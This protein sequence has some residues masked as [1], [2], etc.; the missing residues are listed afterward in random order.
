MGAL[1]SRPKLQLVHALEEVYTLT[2]APK[3]FTL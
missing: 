2:L 3:G 1:H